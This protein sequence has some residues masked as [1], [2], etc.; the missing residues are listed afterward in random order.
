MEE[1]LRQTS[2]ALVRA[3]E[4]RDEYKAQV[5]KL[6]RAVAAA[7]RH[8]D[9]VV[10]EQAAK[11]A[12]LRDEAV[13]VQ[14]QLADAIAVQQELPAAGESAPETEEAAG[15]R[16]RLAE[17]NAAYAQKQREV[18]E[19][20]KALQLASTGNAQRQHDW[21]QLCR[22]FYQ[23]AKGRPVTENERD[24]LTR[25]VTWRREQPQQKQAKQA[26]KKAGTK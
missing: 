4:S 9:T 10:A 23:S 8:A 24:I 20:T 26:R 3:R 14:R 13:V 21:D 11:T 12:A 15:Y 22:W 2:A 5:R 6:E 7:R 17:G 16:K 1:T 18:Q 19:L 25:W